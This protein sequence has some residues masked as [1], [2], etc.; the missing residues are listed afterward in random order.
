MADIQTAGNTNSAGSHA[1]GILM[2]VG[3]T[4]FF[5]LAGIFTKSTSADA[6]TVAC[7]RGLI[8]AFVIAAYVWIRR[9]RTAPGK[10]FELGWRGW[11]LAVVGGLAAVL[12]VASF[13]Y[14]Y[15][16]NVTA[17]YASVP[18]MAAALDW[19]ATR[20]R[21]RGQTMVTAA[22]SL[23]GVAIIVAGGIGSG[24]LFGDGVAIAMTFVSAVYLV[25]VRMFRETPVIWAAAL[26][27][28]LTFAAGWFF[29]DP[30]AIGRHDAM[31]V[32][33]FGFTF[34]TAVI[35]WT[36]GARLL[37]ASEAG[38]IG[39]VEVP[40][41]ILLAWLILSEAPPLQ[42]MIGG[43]IVLIAVFIHAG[44]DVVMQRRRAF[45]TGVSSKS[46]AEETSG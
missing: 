9:D 40:L 46:V 33:V 30:L 22:I 1:L 27:A 12:F 26:S 43:A 28:L 39:A 23:I 31:I 17:I 32:A 34:A 13:K 8:G 36:E 19:I 16:A 4:V 18:F 7:W 41:A 10:S 2:I 11:S 29:T 35:F 38:L 20:Q 24:R 14:T 15:V 37:P 21:A 3:S 5:A 6:W 25:M 45:A 42:S 44:R